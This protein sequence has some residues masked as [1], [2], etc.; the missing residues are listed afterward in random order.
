MTNYEKFKELA[1]AGNQTA[2]LNIYAI[3]E[4]IDVDNLPEKPIDRFINRFCVNNRLGKG[5]TH[6]TENIDSSCT[7]HWNKQH[8]EP[9]Q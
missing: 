9:K 8:K 4:N 1:E 3:D 6:C 2:L 5:T 7:K